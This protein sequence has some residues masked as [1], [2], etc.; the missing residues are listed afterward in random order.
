MNSNAMEM[1]NGPATAENID[2]NEYYGTRESYDSQARPSMNANATERHSITDEHGWDL[3]QETDN[4][5]LRT[6]CTVSE[7]SASEVRSM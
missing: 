2:Y 4:S 6:M 5:C 1:R 7:L 3:P